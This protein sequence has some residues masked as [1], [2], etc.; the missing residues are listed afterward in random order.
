[1]KLVQIVDSLEYIRDNCWQHQLYERLHSQCDE[2]VVLT[3]AQLGSLELPDN[4]VLL[5]T[6]KLRTAVSV[7]PSL[8]LRDR[9]IFVYDQD[10]WE[11]LTDQAGF[12]GAYQSLASQLNVTFINTSKWWSDY[13]NSLGIRSIFTRMWVKPEYCSEGIPWSSRPIQVGFKGTV[14]P[15]RRKAIQELETLGVRVTVLPPSDYSGF[16]CDLSKM[17]FFFHEELG[18]RWTINGDYIIKNCGWA[19]EIE[20]ASQGCFALRRAE[21]EMH[22]YGYP[23]LRSIVPYSDVKEVPELIKA[24]VE[25]PNT[26]QVSRDSVKYVRDHSGWFEL[27][28]LLQTTNLG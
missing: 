23:E 16:L 12:P 2:H 4:D 24:Y 9:R 11:A 28:T 22:A 18:E 8:N 14:H 7:L 17:Q 21:P 5:S 3:R 1:M 10:P 19:K 6:L 25:S 13:V 26:D 15:H 27:K 20:I